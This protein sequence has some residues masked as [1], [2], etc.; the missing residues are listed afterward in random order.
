MNR[1][2]LEIADIVRSAGQS[3]LQ[4]SQRW[5]SWQH[6]KVLLAITRCRTAALGG[7]RDRCSGC[8]HTAISY[9]S[10]R[11][12]HCPKCQGNARQRWLEAFAA[13]SS[14][15]LRACCRWA[16]SRPIPLDR[17]ATL[18][19]SPHQSAWSRLPRE[20]RRWIKDSVPPGQTPVPWTTYPAVSTPS[21]RIL[22]SAAL[23]S[24]LGR[25]RQT[26]IRW[27]GPCPTL[28]RQ[29]YSPGRHLQPQARCSYQP[30][31]H[32]SLERFRSWQ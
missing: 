27:A 17:L 18:F 29:L 28:S 16:R 3:F 10:C 22:A 4:R 32:L 7:H 8:G 11:N 25:V 30:G 31:R 24:R 2:P 13:S 23:P 5:I 14:Y 21:L 6:Q 15:S 12:R 20:V 26:A 19:L 1:P 9:N